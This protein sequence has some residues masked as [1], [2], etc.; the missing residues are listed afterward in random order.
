MN[1][2]QQQVAETDRRSA[3]A[4]R[5]LSALGA[6]IIAV[7]ALWSAGLPP[8]AWFVSVQRWWS[9]QEASPAQTGSVVASAPP[10]SANGTGT[11]VPKSSDTAILGTGSSLSPMPLPL[12]LV[13]T[14]PGRNRNEGIAQIGTS[15]RNPQT[16]GVGSILVNG[17]RLAEIH[18]DHVLLIRGDQSAELYI[19]QP[20]RR[21]DQRGASELLTVGAQPQ[22]PLPTGK[23]NEGLTDYLRPSPFYD[24][25]GLRGYQ[26]YPGARSHVF[27]GLGLQPGDVIT[28]IND[29]PL[30]EPS[31]AIE[32][33]MQLMHGV[34]V[35]ATVERRN[36]SHRITLDGALISADK[37]SV[38]EA[39]VAAKAPLP[40][41]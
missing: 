29:V 1:R 41:S 9:S 17:A 14:T 36:A 25:Q 32:M 38:E 37:E 40:S 4:I 3:L 28:S 15:V 22:T 24:G 11:V 35:A 7:L 20:D 6:A 21:A 26:V 10:S 16:Y 12:Y 18:Q 34:A 23:V 33:F 13:A 19:Y 8:S 39:S 31:Q 27:A 5:G 2:Y 30:N